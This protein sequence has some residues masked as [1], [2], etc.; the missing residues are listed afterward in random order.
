[1]TI[2]KEVTEFIQKGAVLAI[3]ISGGKDSQA[4]LK[5]VMDWYRKENLTNKIFAIHSDLGEMEW[6]QTPEFVERICKDL[7]VELVVVRSEISLLNRMENRRV[8]LEGQNKPHFPSFQQRYCTSKMKIDPINKYLK[9]FDYVVSI[10]GIRWQESK[11]RSL[12][13]RVAKREGM[14]R[15]A[16]TWNA[17]CDFTIDEVWGTYKQTQDTLKEAQ[18]YYRLTNE[19]PDWWNFHPVYAKG[20]QRLSCAICVLGSKNDVANGVKHN[21]KLAQ[22]IAESE[23]KSGFSFT[24]STNIGKLIEKQNQPQNTLF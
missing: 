13:P 12:K 17:I 11:A 22:W 6:E 9:Q 21:P 2:P 4:L 7:G 18:K 23:K 16:I 1:M 14:K 8:Q 3:S 10:E 19:V 24:Q 20:N 5:S 15:K